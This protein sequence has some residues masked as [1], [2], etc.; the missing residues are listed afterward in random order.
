MKSQKPITFLL[1]ILVLVIL[2]SILFVVNGVSTKREGMDNPTM[3]INPTMMNIPTVPKV[4]LPV[5]DTF[6]LTIPGIYANGENLYQ[7]KLTKLNIVDS[8]GKRPNGKIKDNNPTHPNANPISTIYNITDANLGKYNYVTNYN[9][10]PTVITVTYPQPITISKIGLGWGQ[11][12]NKQTPTSPIT[13]KL[14]K[15][16]SIVWSGTFNNSD[17]GGGNDYTFKTS[18]KIGIVNNV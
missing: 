5:A 13:L 1:L 10:D 6:I 14:L 11:M 4:V 2:F 12:E 7:A 15:S 3:M 16:G 18:P 8:T 9:L 17:K